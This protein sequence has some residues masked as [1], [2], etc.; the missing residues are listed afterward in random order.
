MSWN[1]TT[2]KEDQNELLIDGE[3]QKIE[4]PCHSVI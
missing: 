2:S 1:F 3:S 4:I